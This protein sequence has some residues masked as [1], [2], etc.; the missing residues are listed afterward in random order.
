MA[1]FLLIRHAAHADVGHR[2]SGRLPGLQLG[3]TGR[4]QATALAERLAHERVDA[5]LSSPLERTVQTA[6]AI[7]GRH[8]LAVGIADA[9]IEIDFGAWTGRTF[10]ELDGQP[11][12]ST[13]N[14][15][16]GGAQ[17]PG[18]ERMAEAQARIVA[19]LE[20]RAE[21][22]PDD[23]VAIV[24]HC[25][26]IRAAVCHVLGIPLDH[27]LRLAVDPASVTRVTMGR[28]GGCVLSLNEGGNR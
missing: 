15:A 14:V 13:W 24:T 26:M 20:A 17:A 2:L 25:D 1:T 12:W 7:A 5:V 21:R 23:T 8:G 16:R 27:L 3:E 9:L 28:H 10:A 4:A 19:Y 11:L 6:E 18:G 22:T